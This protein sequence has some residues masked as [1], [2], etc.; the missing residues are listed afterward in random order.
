MIKRI[1]LSFLIVFSTVSSAL[2]FGVSSANAWT[3]NPLPLCEG[4]YL[5]FDWKNQVNSLPFSNNWEANSDNWILFREADKPDGVL[6]LIFNAST[7][8][9]DSIL[10][11]RGA[12]L[13]GFV[14]YDFRSFGKNKGDLYSSKIDINTNTFAAENR[15]NVADVDLS[16][17]GV[18]CVQEMHG[19]T[20]AESFTDNDGAIGQVTP[21]IRPDFTYTVNSKDV[22]AKDYN[23]E[24][25]EFTPDEGYTFKGYSVEWSL[26]KCS[27]FTTPGNFC[28]DDE[29]VNH[30][31]QPQDQ[32]YQFSVD[33]Y[34]DYTL[35]AQYLVQQ[36]YRYPSYPA[37]P[38]HCFY[39]DLE[40]EMPDYEFLA[41][42][43]H[44]PI[45]GTNINGDT[46]DGECDVSGFCTPPS[47]YED[48]ST[49][50][51][52]VGG[53]VGCLIRNFQIWFVATLKALFVPSAAFMEGYFNDF[54]SFITQKFGF[55]VWPL[56]FAY[57]FIN[58]FFD[59]LDGTNNICGWSF[60]NIFNSDFKLN[61][62]SLEQNFPSAFNTARYMIQAFTVFVLV[63]GLYMHYRRI[64]QT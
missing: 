56:T 31:I 47:P 51:L 58:A 16:F 37:T 12:N 22:S 63:S 57:D 11:F 44:L 49:Y 21:E 25:P 19:E 45:D 14:S 40:T 18:S 26:R 50:G 3:T 33:S 24:L 52:D 28:E 30:Q 9:N 64:I 7:A 41:T 42:T 36:C 6:T 38:D 27:E 61:F 54:R 62:C 8:S 5:G 23:L 55:L 20:Y 43:V 53:Y 15:N 10:E 13:D 39:V 32:Q 59:G 46:K 48:C 35:S 2:F 1:F 29:L 34:S 4:Y 17:G 60:G